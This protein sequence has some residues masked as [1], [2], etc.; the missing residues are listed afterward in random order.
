MRLQI[1]L[2][3][4][5]RQVKG[6]AGRRTW[7]T[8]RLLVTTQ[9][10][11]AIVL[12]VCS[13]LFLRTLVNL[14]AADLGFA[15]DRLLYAR[16]EPRSG[17][18]P[19]GQRVQFF[20][21][22]VA[23]LAQLPGVVAASAATNLPFGGETSVGSATLFVCHAGAAADG[24]EP[25]AVTV[26]AI[27]PDY[28]KTLSVD[29]LAGRDLVWADGSGGPQRVAIVVNQALAQQAF[30]T[31][32]AIDQRVVIAP[33]CRTAGPPASGLPVVGVVR[34]VRSD[35]RTPPSP[36]IYWPLAFS[37]QPTTL[38]VRTSADPAT[39]IATVRR[40]VTEI[41]A[42]IPTFSEAPLA[43]L[44]ERAL[45]RERLL[46]TLLA[47]FATVTV[48]VSALGIYG[49]LRLRRDAS[50]RGDW[51]PHGRRRRCAR[52]DRARDARFAGRRRSRHRG[53]PGRRGRG[54]LG[55]ALDVLWRRA[56]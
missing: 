18:L 16:V 14:R 43:T 46:S 37:G 49:L 36:M 1:D 32:N 31:A 7:T 10:A 50:P 52:R 41:N 13:G 51:H 22:T 20:E 4:A 24:R 25:I 23:R 15:T 38:L 28:F 2:I 44:R 35:S 34:D 33:D 11:L 45:R 54:P 56:R 8:G 3:A 27:A 39:M 5:I 9:T 21:Q 42:D 53:W 55:A 48:L 17:N 29:V 47:L 26:S 6:D 30:G 12:L 19:P 40:A